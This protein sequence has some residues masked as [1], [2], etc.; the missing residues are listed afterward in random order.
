M[1][2][3]AG[4]LVFWAVLV[5]APP[6]LVG[7]RG[8]DPK[9]QV[10]AE[11][12][13]R[14]ALISAV[15]GVVLIAGLLFT[16][17]TYQSTREGQVTDRYSAA[18][19]QIGVKETAVRLGGIFALERIAVD[20][21]RDRG[22]IIEI[23]AAIVRHAHRMSGTDQPAAEVVAALSVLS[24]LPGSDESRMIDLRSSDLR[25][26]RLPTLRLAGADL[27][28]ALLDGAQIPGADLRWAVLD[29]VTGSKASLIGAD[30]RHAVATGAKFP[31]AYLDRTDMRDAQFHGGEF[32][33]SSMRGL[34]ARKATLE[35]V[36]LDLAQM[37]AADDGT[38]TR[39]GGAWLTKSSL[40]NT[41]LSGVDLRAALGLTP[42][43]RDEA[44]ANA[45]TQWPEMG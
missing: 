27:T 13:A 40:T 36:H 2:L 28:G 44:Y 21:A 19:D 14:G 25:G 8:L 1:V 15:G 7:E 6:L 45:S 11:S 5:W 16:A 42:A 35:S 33:A 34:D 10:A 12:D 31:G 37:Q 32:D 3:G 29:R 20:S 22:T 38:P 17:R 4:A 18:V 39:L 41:N 23:L 24:R 9:D 30:L 43:Q 26:L